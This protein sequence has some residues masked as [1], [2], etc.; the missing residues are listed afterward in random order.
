[1]AVTSTGVISSFSASLAT[2]F[3]TATTP[4]TTTELVDAQQERQST[5]VRNEF[6]AELFTPDPS[7]QLD[8]LV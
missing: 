6:S 7:R 5:Q 4:P 1:M 3:Q 8:I 2:S